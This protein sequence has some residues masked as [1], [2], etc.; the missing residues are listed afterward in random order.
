M[1]GSCAGL[2][3][4]IGTFDAAGSSLSGRYPRA[5]PLDLRKESEGHG[6]DE[7]SKDL[8]WREARDERRKA[9]FKVSTQ[10]RWFLCDILDGG[11]REG[12]Y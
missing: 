3:A 5:S 9:F 11:L 4:L 12:K 1:F 8:N 7:G 2:A 6:H 10:E